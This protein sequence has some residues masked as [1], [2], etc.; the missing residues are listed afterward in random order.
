MPPGL[1]RDEMRL[2]SWSL[3]LVGRG[4]RMKGSIL[5]AR[6]DD[7]ERRPGH[8][9]APVQDP[10]L[11]PV[12]DLPNR[13]WRAVFIG[14][15]KL[16]QKPFRSHPARECVPY[17]SSPWSSVGNIKSLPRGVQQYLIPVEL[18]GASKVT[19]PDL[20]AFGL[21]FRRER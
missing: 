16:T 10:I 9:Q 12:D 18:T 7:E 14:H 1:C 19:V 5:L 3:A 2:A 20:I 6:V 21:K 4:Q 17:V 15:P 13:S 8:G 11:P